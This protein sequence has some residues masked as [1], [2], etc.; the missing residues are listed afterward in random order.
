MQRAFVQKMLAHS[1]FSKHLTAV[2]EINAMLRRALELREGSAEP[3]AA[4][5][6]KV[7]DG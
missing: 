3:S 4:A 1:V 2:R 7:G 5:P 6:I